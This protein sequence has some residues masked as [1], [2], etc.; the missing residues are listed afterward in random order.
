M[1]VSYSLYG[2][3]ELTM[4]I[5]Q[6]LERER[7]ELKH[8]ERLAQERAMR[9]AAMQ[10][11]RRE[12]NNTQRERWTCLL[13]AC[14]GLEPEQACN[15]Y[16]I[17]FADRVLN[18]VVKDARGGLYMLFQ[19]RTFDQLP[20]DEQLR[21]GW[22]EELEANLVKVAASELDLMMAGCEE[23]CDDDDGAKYRAC[24]KNEFLDKLKEDYQV[25]LDDTP[26]DY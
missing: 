16:A 25:A 20:W 12:F 17:F 3:F 10:A 9:K 6:A 21:D 15:P 18:E 24:L 19:Q 4:G 13:D 23:Q 26:Y 1:L 11:E 22:N 2:S 5:V 7:Y 14:G 8:A